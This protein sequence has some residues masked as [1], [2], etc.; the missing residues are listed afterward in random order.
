MYVGRPRATIRDEILALWSVQYLALSPSLRLLVAPGSDAFILASAI[1]VQ[2][3]GLEAQM[4][5]V[6]RDI[7]P[8]QASPEA[9]ARHGYV[10]G[11]A[12]RPGTVARHSAPV[13]NAVDGVK[14]IPVGSRMAYSDGTLYGV[15]ETSVTITAGTGVVTA[16]AIEPGSAGTRDTGDVLTWTA[17][18]T[19]LD[20][21]GTVASGPTAVEGTDEESIADWA[22]HII[23]LRRE[24]PGSGNRSEWRE[25]CTDYIGTEIETAYI[26]PLLEPPSTYPG[27]GVPETP[28]CVTVVAVGPAQGAS[29]V[30]KRLVPYDDAN[31]R[32][33]GAELPRIRGYIEGTYTITGVP[34]DTGTM[35]RPVTMLAENASVEAIQT[36]AENVVIACE[37]NEANA[38][39]WTGSHAITSAS[40]TT[41][42]V[43]GDQTA[44]NGKIAQVLVD[45]PTTTNTRG[46]YRV[47]TLPVGVFAA[48]ETTWTFTTPFPDT[49]TGTLYPATPADAL[50]RTATFSLFDG[51]GPGDTSPASRWPPESAGARATL[52]RSAL[53]AAVLTSVPSVSPQGALVLTPTGVLSAEVTTPAVDVTP[54]AKTVVILGRLL[55]V[56]A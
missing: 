33:S 26:Y 7:L 18:I 29:V 13:T 35:L 8:D 16:V 48:G 54:G 1:A 40:T 17:A 20:P 38:F 44:L 55:L 32:T 19:G 37:M 34:T 21:T 43:A 45:A 9:V 14:T 47:Y 50:I 41:I 51:L 53:A 28:G 2:L 11:V 23:E 12:R 10:D 3:E 6:G 22:Q 24:R 56:A 4:E 25:W 36:T 39:A 5:Q 30:N 49:P 31:A 52:Y 42:V 27:A 46:G 15:S